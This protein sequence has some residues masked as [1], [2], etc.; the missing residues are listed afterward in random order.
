MKE[1][2]GKELT[3]KADEQ[4]LK[5]FSV[6]LENLLMQAPLK[7]KIVLGVDPAYRTG[8]KLAVVDTTGKVLHIDKV[9][10]T[11][12]KNNYDKEKQLLL[13]LIQQY[14]VEIIAIGN[15]TASRE[16]EAFIAKLIQENHLE[17]RF[18]DCQ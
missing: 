13:K 1:K 11:I 16:T 2:Y 4:A 18:C 15:G 8:C 17:C 10:I 6:N 5:V 9:F 12:P 7:N 3:Q 14:H